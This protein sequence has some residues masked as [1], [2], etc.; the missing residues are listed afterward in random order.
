MVAMSNSPGSPCVEIFNDCLPSVGSR[1]EP[2][3]SGRSRHGFAVATGG[4]RNGSAQRARTPRWPRRPR[5]TTQSTR[6]PSTV[7]AISRAGEHRRPGQ[8]ALRAARATRPGSAPAT[9]RFPNHCLGIALRHRRA[10][11]DWPRQWRRHA[12]P[13]ARRFGS[14]PSTSAVREARGVPF[15]PSAGLSPPR[16]SRRVCFRPSCRPA[17]LDLRPGSGRDVPLD[18]RFDRVVSSRGTEQ[19]SRRRVKPCGEAPGGTLRTGEESQGVTHGRDDDAFQL[20]LY[21]PT[22]HQR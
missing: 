1:Q 7:G 11:V 6:L 13:A 2:P 5:T 9:T 18:G 22:D 20:P 10:W 19:G 3:L 4:R 8:E 12:P 16:A 14:R 21:C 17:E 15:R